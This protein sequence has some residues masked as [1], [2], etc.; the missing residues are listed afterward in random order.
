V[1]AGGTELRNDDAR[2]DSGTTGVRSIGSLLLPYV[3]ATRLKTPARDSYTAVNSL[4]TANFR[5]TLFVRSSF[6]G[7]MDE[8]C[9][10]KSFRRL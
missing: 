9:V 2:D 4:Q 8:H 6:L 3:V 1:K 5:V 7:S 10:S